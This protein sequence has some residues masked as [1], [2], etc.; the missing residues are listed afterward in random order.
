MLSLPQIQRHVLSSDT[1]QLLGDLARNGTLLPLPIRL[2]LSHSIEAGLGL[3]LRR[4]AEL[5]HGPTQLSRTIMERLLMSQQTLE[6]QEIV[7]LVAQ[8]AGLARALSLGVV[9]ADLE[10]PVLQRLRE[11]SF[12]LASLQASDGLLGTTTD[13]READRV[14]SSAFAVYLLAPVRDEVSLVGIAA[15]LTAL[16]ERRP[17]DDPGSEELVEVALATW[18][19]GQG[20]RAQWLDSL[21]A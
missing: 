20:V 7:V 18:P 16:E 19:R 8:M 14:R 9:D 15:L 4:V 11:L 13:C 6:G 10:T 17:L 2:Q 12:T 3:A 5:T 1:D 21:A